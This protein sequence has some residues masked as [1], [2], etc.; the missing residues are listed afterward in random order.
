MLKNADSY[1][2]K[3]LKKEPQLRQVIAA[4][5]AEAARE[6]EMPDRVRHCE[7]GGENV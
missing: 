2:A 4:N 3:S 7:G 6:G 1:N 5:V